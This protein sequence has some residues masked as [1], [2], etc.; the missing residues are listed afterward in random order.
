MKKQRGE[1]WAYFLIVVLIA[2][3]VWMSFYFWQKRTEEKRWL[4]EHKCFLENKV[5]THT[6]TILVPVG[7]IMIPQIHNHYEYTYSCDNGQTIIHR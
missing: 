2:G 5:F 6:S 4:E 1:A 3:A 7:K